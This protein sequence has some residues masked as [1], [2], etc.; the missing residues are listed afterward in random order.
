ML[1]TFFRAALQGWPATIL[2]DILHIRTYSPLPSVQSEVASTPVQVRSP[3]APATPVVGSPLGPHTPVVVSPFQPSPEVFLFQIPL[4]VLQSHQLE[5]LIKATRLK[6]EW[7]K[8]CLLE[9]QGDLTKA[10]EAFNTLKAQNRITQDML[11]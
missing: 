4:I 1:L 3:V 7:A 5:Q 9:N 2:N 11:Q 10:I 8:Q 6:P